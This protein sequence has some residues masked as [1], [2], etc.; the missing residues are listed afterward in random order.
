MGSDRHYPEEAPAHRVTVSNFWMDAHPVTNEQFAR[1]VRE[2]GH[3]TFAELDPKAEDY[4]GALPEMLKAGSLLFSRPTGPVD[5]RDFRNWWGFSFGADWRHPKGPKSD[6]KRKE[7]YPVVHV[8]Y[9]D[10]EAYARWAGKEIPNGSG[11]GV[12][13]VGRAQ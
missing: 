3:V 2:T 4:P 1:F 8:A 5:L 10:A 7:K 13:C 12:R 11:V 9:S 6:I